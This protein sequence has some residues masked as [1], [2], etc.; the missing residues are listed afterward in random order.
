[1]SR[2]ANSVFACSLVGCVSASAFAAPQ[3]APARPSASAFVPGTGTC[4]EY[5]SDDFEEPGWAFSHRHPKSSREQDERTR[6]PMG[7]STNDRWHEG[8]ERGQPDHIQVVA[9]PRGGL[10]GSARA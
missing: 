9:T 1:M 4:I 5:V 10:E 2:I 7:A 6:S 8:P 3:A